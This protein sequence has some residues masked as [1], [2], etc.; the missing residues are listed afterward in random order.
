MSIQ[1]LERFLAAVEA[2][3]LDT[4]RASYHPDAVIWHSTDG[5]E[6]TVDQN[7]T[8]LSFIAANLPGMHYTNVRRYGFEGG[9]VEQHDTVIPIPG[10]DEPHVMTACLVVLFDGDGRVT[11]VDEYIDTAA[12]AG[13]TAAVQQA[14]ANAR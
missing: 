11:R 3:D 6:Q 14:A 7:L 1:A 8:T 2:G 4:V 13:L 12:V 10:R 9:A 5:I